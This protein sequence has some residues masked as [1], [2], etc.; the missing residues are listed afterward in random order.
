MRV[1]ELASRYAKAVFEL[2][3]ENK[4][5]EK[6]FED[7]RQLEQVFTKDQEV[8]AFLVSPLIKAEQRAA[9][10]KQVL[11]NKGLSKEA[12]DLVLLLAQKDRMS[13]FA[14]VAR[15]FQDEIDSANN[16]CRGVVRS[17]VALGQ[18]ERQK[19][20]ETVERVL[21]KKVIMTYKVDPSVIGGLVAQVGSYTFDDSIATHLRRMNEELKRRT[22]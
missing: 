4:T 3:V 16:V 17:A 6:V 1:S 15:A 20:E 8:Q 5:Q 12:Y 10:M 21:S 13:L 2:A 19:I 22:V 11:E 7:L 9:V 14:D 18:A